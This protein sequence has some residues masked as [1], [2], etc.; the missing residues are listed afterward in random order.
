ME[1]PVIELLRNIEKD[2]N[3]ILENE[4]KH[5]LDLASSLVLSYGTIGQRA[6]FISMLEDVLKNFKERIGDK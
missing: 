5:I 6:M 1:N 2:V 4:F 3:D